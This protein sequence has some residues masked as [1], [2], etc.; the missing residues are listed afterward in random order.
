M[1]P[2]GIEP[3]FAGAVRVDVNGGFVLQFGGV[4]LCPFGRSE[5]APF[6]A[7]PER[8]DDGALRTPAGLKQ[9]SQPTPAKWIALYTSTGEMPGA[10]LCS[11][12]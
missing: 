12:P 8:E 2:A 7:V 4:L 11:E 6:L 1:R 5:Q 3:P 9:F 10:R